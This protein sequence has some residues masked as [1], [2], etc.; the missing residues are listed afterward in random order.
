MARRQT[1]EEHENHERWL[2]SYADFI[3]LLFAFFVVMYSVSSVDQKR[4]VQA[5]KSVRW[6][7]HFKGTG[8]TA[9]FPLFKG[10]PAGGNGVVDG[11]EPGGQPMSITADQSRK[12]VEQRFMTA[13]S[14][15]KARGA[16]AVEL[17]GT[18]LRVRLSTGT[19][20]D[21]GSAALRPDALP[22]LDILM[23]EVAQFQRP[24]RVEGHTD[25]RTATST[26]TRNNWEL[27]ALRAASVVA[28]LEAAHQY[29][30]RLLSVVG[31]GAS[32][33]LQDNAT[34]DGREANRRIELCV[35]F[36]VPGTRGTL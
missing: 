32:K 36:D 33:P 17:E 13:M 15:A 9:T 16:V 19:F 25:D 31:H 30:P 14:N 26:R 3:T 2:V 18:V 11:S 23:D 10:A 5:Q 24:L 35:E 28:Y 27:S 22:L 20:F 34:A 1:H 12:R 6:A 7:M 8:G 4:V 29:P 21:P